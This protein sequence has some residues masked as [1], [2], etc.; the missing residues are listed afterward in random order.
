MFAVQAAYSG[1]IMV[2]LLMY[3][4]VHELIHKL[5]DISLVGFCLVQAALEL[6]T[7]NSSFWG[8]C[9]RKV[10]CGSLQL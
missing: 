1:C 5:Y 2:K 9:I 6:Q 7:F 3:A 8:V 4:W 10:P